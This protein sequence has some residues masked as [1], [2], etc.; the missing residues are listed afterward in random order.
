LDILDKILINTKD[1]KF[2]EEIISGANI[3]NPNLI[4]MIIIVPSL[5]RHYNFLNL[6]KI[7]ANIL[8]LCQN[9]E[10]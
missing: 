8:L 3:L 7:M 4:D 6:H 2:S 9:F 5:V 10:K 1:L